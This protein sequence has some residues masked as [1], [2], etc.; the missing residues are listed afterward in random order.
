MEAPTEAEETAEAAGDAKELD[1]YRIAILADM[2]S[3]MSGTSLAPVHL[4]I[5]MLCR[6]IIGP[7]FMG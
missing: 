6:P 2:T 1:V 3:Q 7:H 4:L 5:T